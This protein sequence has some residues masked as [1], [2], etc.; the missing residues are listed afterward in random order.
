MLEPSPK[1][2]TTIRVINQ[3]MSRSVNNYWLCFGALWGIVMNKGVIPD[4]DLDICVMYGE[5]YNKI[6][7]TFLC[8]PGGYTMAH[9]L[10]DDVTGKALH[11]SFNSKTLPHICLSF[12]Y[13]HNGI[14]YFC[15]DQNFEVSGIGVPKSGYFFKGVPDSA[16]QYF[17]MVEWPGI[18]QMHKINVPRFPGAVLDNLYPDWAYRKQRYN[19]KNNNVEEEK[20]VSYHKGGAI[21]PYRVHVQSMSSFSDNKGIEIELLKNK[22]SYDTEIKRRN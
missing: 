22:A 6:Q 21:S 17:R 3:V 11:C 9:A 15:H 8:A 20:M 2:E 4:G 5:D 12:W 10:V 14:R 18:N 7:K 16:L 13:P 1:I 19:I